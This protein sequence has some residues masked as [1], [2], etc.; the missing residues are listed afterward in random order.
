MS[1]AALVTAVVT[2]KVSAHVMRP[3]WTA[4]VSPIARHRCNVCWAVWVTSAE[5]HTNHVGTAPLKARAREQRVTTVVAAAYKHHDPAAV[6]A[7]GLLP[8]DV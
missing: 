1:Q 6:D 4:A 7:T 2:R 3:A 8:Q 5:E